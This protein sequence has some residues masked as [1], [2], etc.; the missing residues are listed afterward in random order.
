LALSCFYCNSAK[1]ANIAGRDPETGQL[2]R[3]YHPRVDAWHEHFSWSAETLVA[4]WGERRLKCYG[5]IMRKAGCY[6][7]HSSRKISFR[8]GV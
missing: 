7:A 8:L 6:D 2:T 4:T 1:G 3:L 5:S